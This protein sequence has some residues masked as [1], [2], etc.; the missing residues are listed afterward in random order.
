M[1]LCCCLVLCLVFF[2]QAASFTPAQRVVLVRA[3][4]LSLNTLRA[5]KRDEHKSDEDDLVTANGNSK[6]EDAPNG[7]DNVQLVKQTAV[8]ILMCF[9]FENGADRVDKDRLRTRMV[10]DRTY[11]RKQPFD[12]ENM[13]I[14]PSLE[15]LLPV[16]VR[17]QEG[18][19]ITAPARFLTFLVAYFIFPYLAQLLNGLVDMSPH[20]LDNIVSKFVPGISILYGAFISLTLSILYQRQKDI[21]E[22]IARESA[23][24][25]VCTRNLISLFRK[26][27]DLMVEGVRCVADQIRVLVTG[28]RGSELMTIIYSD[29]YTRI[30]DLIN[31]EEERIA[32][33]KGD[34]YRK[35]V[36]AD[37]FFR[38]VKLNH[39]DF[40]QSCSR[41]YHSSR[42][43]E[44]AET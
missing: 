2:D 42:F 9:I 19:W 26:D 33:R 39:L 5:S 22:C 7:A 16:P 30:L 41:H 23:L 1:K 12:K 8:E 28:S 3:I 4:P 37:L 14:P 31:D 38:L 10:T 43:W 32:E 13:I 35:G 44:I 17:W 18:F 20:Q 24:L 11:A 6:K 15:D 36:S 25:S 29:P 21:Q 40:S 27:R 34:I